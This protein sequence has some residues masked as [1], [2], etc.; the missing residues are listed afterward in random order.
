MQKDFTDSIAKTKNDPEAA[1][2]VLEGLSAE[3]LGEMQSTVAEVVLPVALKTTS[4][5]Y[6]T[7]TAADVKE[8]CNKTKSDR[9]LDQAL[10]EE[11]MVYQAPR[12]CRFQ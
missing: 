1:K 5:T 11:C 10:D 8:M 6:L 7:G 9:T 4:W 2:K 3:K 12:A